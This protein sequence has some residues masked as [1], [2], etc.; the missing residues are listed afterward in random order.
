MDLSRL[1]KEGLGETLV[2]SASSDSTDPAGLEG[3]GRPAVASS[4]SAAGKPQRKI[5]LSLLALPLAIAAAVAV[6]FVVILFVAI[7]PAI[8]VPPPVPK[9]EDIVYEKSNTRVT[10]TVLDLEIYGRVSL[11]LENQELLVWQEI[12][13]GDGNRVFGY[14]F[15]MGCSKTRNQHT[16][17][18]F[19]EE[20]KSF[21]VIVTN[22]KVSF[23]EYIHVPNSDG[24]TDL[25]YNPEEFPLMAGQN[26]AILLNGIS[27]FSSDSS[28]TVNGD[29]IL[30]TVEGKKFVSQHYDSVVTLESVNGGTKV[31]FKPQ[32]AGSVK[33]SALGSK[34]QVSCEFNVYEHPDDFPDS[35]RDFTLS[36]DGRTATFKVSSLGEK[37]VLSVE[38]KVATV[39]WSKTGLPVTN[40]LHDR[41]DI[42]FSCTYEIDTK[43]A[44]CTVASISQTNLEISNISANTG[45]AKKEIY[46]N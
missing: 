2:S 24:I 28:I 37:T 41:D 25:R 20:E 6:G 23:D 1:G 40:L 8:L 9:I 32:E 43:F 39:Y 14:N 19:W 18:V 10:F 12:S 35:I 7:G 22:D 26:A 46:S 4:P 34:A 16:C 15:E 5:S 17:Y 42:S 31:N 29:E 36:E 11:L 13:P 38:S 44:M 21:A 3:V 27:S 30:E 33:I 45:F